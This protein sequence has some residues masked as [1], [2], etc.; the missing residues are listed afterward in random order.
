[1]KKV[2]AITENPADQTML[3]IV[4]KEPL[5]DLAVQ[6]F[7]DLGFKPK[8]QI[9]ELS[10]MKHDSFYPNALNDFSIFSGLD[11]NFFTYFICKIEDCENMLKSVEQQN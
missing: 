6:V 2:I 11:C 1:M 10:I 3:G 4:V 8:E 7:Q 9:R 5:C